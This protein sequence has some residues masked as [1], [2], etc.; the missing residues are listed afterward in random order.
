MSLKVIAE[1]QGGRP[2]RYRG[3]LGSARLGSARLALPTPASEQVNRS[4][5]SRPRVASSSMADPGSALGILGNSEESDSENEE[6]SDSESQLLEAAMSEE[7][8]WLSWFLGLKAHRSCLA[9]VYHAHV[10]LASSARSR[11]SSS[12]TT[13]TSQAS[14]M[15][16][17]RQLLIGNDS[18]VT[19]SHT[20]TTPWTSSWTWIWRQVLQEV[21]LYECNCQQRPSP[22][23]NRRSSRP[24]RKF[25]TDSSTLGSLT[26]PKACRRCSR[27][28]SVE[29]SGDA[30][31]CSATV[32]RCSQQAGDAPRPLR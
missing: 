8:S 6:P 4:A 24:R 27:S 18:L 12:T 32:S 30:S 9:D 1:R 16:Y 22:R 21:S 28:T 25:S 23:S 13:S 26:R 10:I 2:S 7:S 15:L 17:V 31:E 14:T 19:R 20:T 11:R 3:V 29:T 5:P